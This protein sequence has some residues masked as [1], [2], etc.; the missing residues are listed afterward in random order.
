[1]NE[2]E[3]YNELMK[4]IK[5]IRENEIAHENELK[6]LRKEMKK[7][8]KRYEQLV[9]GVK[10][11]ADEKFKALK[12]DLDGKMYEIMLVIQNEIKE[13]KTKFESMFNNI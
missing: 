6:L 9:I 4:Q 13:I 7:N 3:K 1:M 11:S 12:L 2:D 8:N 5:E 10:L